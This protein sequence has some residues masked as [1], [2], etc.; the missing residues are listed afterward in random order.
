MHKVYAPARAPNL[1]HGSYSD[2]VNASRQPAAWEEIERSSWSRTSASSVAEVRMAGAAP[3]GFRAR[4]SNRP[5]TAGSLPRLNMDGLSSSEEGQRSSRAWKAEGWSP[6]PRKA[7]KNTKAPLSLDDVQNKNVLADAK[8]L[9]GFEDQ[10]A[11]YGPF[12]DARVARQRQKHVWNRIDRKLRAAAEEHERSLVHDL[13]TPRI[14]E[15]SAAEIKDAERR[16]KGRRR[17]ETMAKSSSATQARP[18]TPVM[19]GSP[20]SG[21]IRTEPKRLPS[22]EII[23]PQEHIARP[24]EASPYKHVV[25]PE[26]FVSTSAKPA[27]PPAKLKKADGR[28][29]EKHTGAGKFGIDSQEAVMAVN[30][31]FAAVQ[32]ASDDIVPDETVEE[33]QERPPTPGGSV[34]G[35]PGYAYDR[36]PHIIEEVEKLRLEQVAAQEAGDYK[37]VEILNDRIME[38]DAPEE[39]AVVQKA[40]AEGEAARAE[41]QRRQQ[42]EEARLKASEESAERKALEDEAAASV[43]LAAELVR[44]SHFAEQ[45]KALLKE[46][47]RRRLW[48]DKRPAPH[49]EH[50][51]NHMWREKPE[52]PLRPAVWSS[53]PRKIALIE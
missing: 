36:R 1:L 3:A 22:G 33:V 29:V 40:R 53:P 45:Q 49:P 17:A 20:P 37:Q 5:R 38:L 21:D 26:Y 32:D 50:R 9:R 14:S 15:K 11:G 24:S 18:V 25:M 39:Y 13:A 34:I 44:E 16:K 52:A 10:M 30:L 4:I 2:H 43:A 31:L 6:P 41:Q 42:Q 35:I 19:A 28:E 48:Q 7:A 12:P 23:D 46:E 27:R 47:R 51:H 8:Q